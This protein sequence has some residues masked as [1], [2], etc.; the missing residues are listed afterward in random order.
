[1]KSA[2]RFFRWFISSR[3]KRWLFLYLPVLFLL[4]TVWCNYLVIAAGKGKLY[5]RIEDL[6][7]KNTALVFGTSPWSKGR[8]N[9]FYLFRIKAA[10]DL[11]K[12][13]KV[14]HLL[15]SGDNSTLSYDEATY[16]KNSLKAYG[17]PD[18]VITLDYAGFRTLDSVVRSKWVFG[19]NDVIIVSQE[20]Q[21]E[22]ALFIAEHFGITA[23]GFNA[24][25]VPDRYGFSTS[26][27]EY[28]A[29]VKAVLDVYVLNTQP[30][31]PGPPEPIG[32]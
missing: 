9:F 32:D 19:Q 7:A 14:K 29:R 13:G 2:G 25:D 18:S 20:F 3:W 6:P 28:F 23:V 15:V 27:R 17:V 5:T 1:M 4:F 24:K 26:V 8:K 16:M 12:S 22:R 10:A 31:F 11:W 30:K 21:N